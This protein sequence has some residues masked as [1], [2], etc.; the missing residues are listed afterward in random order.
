[1]KNHRKYLLKSL[2]KHLKTS[3]KTNIIIRG[4]GL[5]SPAPPRLGSLRIFL[6][7]L[8]D[9]ITLYLLLPFSESSNIE[10]KDLP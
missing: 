3:N 4:V 5:S 1:M 8:I 9:T 10:L 2:K 6:T 7:I